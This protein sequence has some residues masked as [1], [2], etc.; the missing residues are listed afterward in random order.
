MKRFLAFLLP[1]PTNKHTATDTKPP[2]HAH[3]T[4]PHTHTQTLSERAPNTK[5]RELTS[6]C[7]RRCKRHRTC[8]WNCRSLTWWTT[9]SG[10]GR[11]PGN[12]RI[13]KS[14]SSSSPSSRS[15]EEY[16][17]GRFLCCLARL[18]AYARWPLDHRPTPQIP[19]LHLDGCDWPS[20][21][22]CAEGPFLLVPSRKI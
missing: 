17:N 7:C 11:E 3:E 8:S 13:G 1:L 16:D 6:S 18:I 21:S 15:S 20:T 14:A 22:P 4:T 2:V 9:R 5:L 19:R 12:R 10:G